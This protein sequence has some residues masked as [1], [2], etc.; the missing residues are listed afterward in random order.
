MSPPGYP[1]VSYKNFRLF[2]PAVW[3][4]RGNIYNIHECLVLLYRQG[5][6]DLKHFQLSK[7][8]TLIDLK[9]FQLLMIYMHLHLKYFSEVENC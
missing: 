8:K 3:L 2:R 4:A 9:H 6:H 1:R 5:G 7:F